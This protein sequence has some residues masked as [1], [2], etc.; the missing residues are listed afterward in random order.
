MWQ[1]RRPGQGRS[2]PRVQRQA[3]ERAMA[4]QRDPLTGAPDRGTWDTELPDA[5]DRTRRDGEPLTLALIDLDFFQRYNDQHGYQAGDRFL[6]SVVAAWTSVLRPGDLLCRYAGE[7]F[8]LILPG[9]TAEQ[10][11]TVLERMRAVTPRADLLLR[12]RELERL[13]K[14]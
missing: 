7:E 14:S 9:A 2:V 4:T 11:M 5:V 13:G 10:A 8:G 12:P 6:K 1:D 3:K